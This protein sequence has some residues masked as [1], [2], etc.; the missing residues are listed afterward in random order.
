M[1]LNLFW[2]VEAEATGRLPLDEF[3]NE[4]CG[5]FTPPVRNVLL[6]DGDLLRK[7]VVA[8]LLPVFA[9]VGPLTVHA[10]VCDDAHREVVDRDAVIL[11]THHFGGHVAGRATGVFGVLGVPHASDT[12]I[13][14]THVTIFVE[15]Q[16]LRLN[17]SVENAVLV[18]VLQTKNYASHEEL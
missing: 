3:I 14:D 8:N 10:L 5:L 13:S 18:E 2:S 9:L 1:L 15:N 16:I 7:D 11:T 17:V 12:Q 4:I 6:L